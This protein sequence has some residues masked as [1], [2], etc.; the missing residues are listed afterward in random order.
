MVCIDDHCMICVCARA[1]ACLHVHV[2]MCVC[3]CVCAGACLET[4]RVIYTGHGVKI[5]LLDQHLNTV[6]FKFS[7]ISDD[8]SMVDTK[9]C[10][11]G[12]TLVHLTLGS[13]NYVW[14]KNQYL[15][16]DISSYLEDTGNN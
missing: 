13:R 4:D 1:C 2:F 6:I 5:M 8:K 16:T 11:V 7:I 15:N 9:T 12:V 14:G 3:V 10:V